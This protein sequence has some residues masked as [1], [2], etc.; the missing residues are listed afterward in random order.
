[1]NKFLLLTLLF[2]SISFSQDIP[3]ECS[4]YLEAKVDKVT[5]AS[6]VAPPKPFIVDNKNTKSGLNMILM[7]SGKRDAAILS[8]QSMGSAKCVDEGDVI[9]IL[10]RDGTRLALGNDGSFNCRGTHTSYFGSVFGGIDQL[11]QLS[12]K[13]IEI[14]RLN[15]QNGIVEETFTVTQSQEFMNTMSCLSKVMVQK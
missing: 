8:V 13:E 12:T 10:F 14:M 1:M 6:N 9:N 3:V 7:L 4:K 5:G 2:T 15:T 11:E